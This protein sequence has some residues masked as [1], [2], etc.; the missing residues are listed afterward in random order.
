MDTAQNM[1]MVT[2]MGTLKYTGNQKFGFP[3][4]FTTDGALSLQTSLNTVRAAQNMHQTV[5]TSGYGGKSV[6]LYQFAPV[7]LCGT[8]RAGLGI[9]RKGTFA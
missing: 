3:D 9:D 1:H 2:A 7:Q 8:D 5:N 6:G 4:E